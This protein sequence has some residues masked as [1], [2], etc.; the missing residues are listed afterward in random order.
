MSTFALILAGG[1][2]T[3]LW[4]LT[5]KGTPKAFLS[6]DGS[7]L[8]LLQRTILRI[9]KIILPER[10]YIS[11][12]TNHEEELQHQAQHIP[13][14]NIILEPSPR[15]TLACIG[16]SGLYIKRQD[17]SSVIV[18][19]PGEQYIGNDVLFQKL[20][21]VAV[22]S[23]QEN[24]CVVTLG[25]K[26]NFPATRFGYIHLGERLFYENDLTVFKS[27]GFTE[28]PDE[29]TAS[30][31]LKSNMYLWNSGIYILPALLLFKLIH[32]LAPDIHDSLSIIDEYIGT[33]R[34]REVIERVYPNIRNISIDYARRICL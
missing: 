3:R 4:P 19:M 15:G 21:S 16:L 20:I 17:P 33:S 10:I 7:G 31:F 14:E 23:A 2:G 25:I 24:N 13:H 32:D 11:A 22:K 29:N 1:L 6:F 28:K 26:P 27:L 34:E 30:E 12:G 8:S 5:A 9:E 18:V